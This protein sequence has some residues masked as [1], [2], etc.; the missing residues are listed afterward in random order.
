MNTAENYK[1]IV[2]SAER[3]IKLIELIAGAPSPLTFTEIKE[4]L[5]IPKSSLSYLLDDLEHYGYVSRNPTSLRYS[6]G[7][8]LVEYSILCINNT[9]TLSEVNLELEKIG[10]QYGEAM[11]A[12]VLDGRF[13]TYISKINGGNK[14]VLTSNIGLR[15][16]A[17]STA[18][19]RVLLA[20]QTDQQIFDLLNGHALERVTPFTLTDLDSLMLEI[21]K[22]REQKYAVETQQSV[23]NAACVAVPVYNFNTHK[24][25]FA[26]SMTV[27]ATKLTPVYQ[28]KII[29]VLQEASRCISVK[30]SAYF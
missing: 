27:A 4:A 1:F 17:H 22:V 19:G 3:T 14:I 16:P 11:H 21:H 6:K 26:I 2:K 15:T 23:L 25:M 28:E 30:V 9:D 12:G 10:K 8:R 18:L 24:I 29:S 7:M 5:K 20:E 13:V